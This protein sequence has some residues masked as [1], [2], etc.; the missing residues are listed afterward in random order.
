MIAGGREAPDSIEGQG[1]EQI[2]A[3]RRALSTEVERIGDDVLVTA[4]L[5]ALDGPPDTLQTRWRPC[6]AGT[7]VAAGDAGTMLERC[8]PWVGE[9]LADWLAE[10]WGPDDRRRYCYEVYGVQR[11]A[12]EVVRT[13][14]DRAAGG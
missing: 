13:R 4:R 11:A 14:R 1:V 5:P 9:P 8:H 7:F 6:G 10:P 12:L 3:A 2:G